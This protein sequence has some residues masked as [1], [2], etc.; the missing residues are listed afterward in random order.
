MIF[1]VDFVVCDQVQL[2][3]TF[4][5]MTL[6]VYHEPTKLWVKRHPEM[7]WV[8]FGVMLVTMISMACCTNV[9]RKAP[10]NF[11]FLGLFT[12]A[13]SFLLG[14]ISARFNVQEVRILRSFEST[15][16]IICSIVRFV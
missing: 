15:V 4:G 2:A 7:M 9:R 14:T 13:Q 16:M 12:L 11:I 3:V 8:A 10:M 6:F 5:I 1:E